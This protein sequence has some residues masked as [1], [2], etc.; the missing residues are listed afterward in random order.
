MI[1]EQH[2]AKCFVFNKAKILKNLVCMDKTDAEGDKQTTGNIFGYPP[3]LCQR[4]G[5]NKDEQTKVEARQY[6]PRTLNAGNG[7]NEL[8]EASGK[9]FL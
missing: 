1:S 6:A 5:R 9:Q 4:L 3:F 2:T 8:E 7:C